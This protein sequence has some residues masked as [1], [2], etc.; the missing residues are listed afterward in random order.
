MGQMK[1]VKVESEAME[2]PER[3]KGEGNDA[4]KAGKYEEALVKYTKAIELTDR[5]NDK[6]GIFKGWDLYI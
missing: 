6:R 4:F 1:E 2:D 5:D 3:L